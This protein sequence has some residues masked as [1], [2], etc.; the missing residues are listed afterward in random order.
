M[1]GRGGTALMMGDGDGRKV[2]RGEGDVIIAHIV[3]D[4]MVDT[5]PNQLQGRLG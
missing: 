4:D 2:E 5:W 1:I 3:P